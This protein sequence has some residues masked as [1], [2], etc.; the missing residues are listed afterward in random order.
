LLASAGE[1]GHVKVWDVASGEELQDLGGQ[2]TP[3]KAVA[4][5][6]DGKI[7]A[8]VGEDSNI[9]LWEIST[10][11]LIHTLD[12]GSY[13][14]NA[15][16][17]SPTGKLYVGDEGNEVSVWDGRRGIKLKESAAKLKAVSPKDRRK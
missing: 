12:R 15:L 14:I 6:P 13:S 7:L 4:F 2:Q 5:D 11:T 17:F 8:S 9:L 16:S 10:G 3:V 1:D